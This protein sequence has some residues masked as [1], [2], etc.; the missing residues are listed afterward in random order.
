MYKFGNYLEYHTYYN[1]KGIE[2]ALSDV[3]SGLGGGHTGSTNLQDA[4]PGVVKNN[5]NLIVIG[6]VLYFLLGS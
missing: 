5:M 1:T 4:V 6:A 3:G 2:M